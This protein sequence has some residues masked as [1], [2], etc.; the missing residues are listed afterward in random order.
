[1]TDED[2][3]HPIIHYGEPFAGFVGIIILVVV[4]LANNA[5][6]PNATVTPTTVLH[7]PAAISPPNTN[8]GAHAKEIRQGPEPA[9]YTFVSGP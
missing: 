2:R 8:G 4:L 7:P 1:M 9:P 6:A 3:V 5:S